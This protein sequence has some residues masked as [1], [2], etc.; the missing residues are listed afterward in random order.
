MSEVD[1]IGRHEVRDSVE[2][3]NDWEVELGISSISRS[4][5]PFP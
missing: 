1:G 2:L 5:P 4:L 3:V